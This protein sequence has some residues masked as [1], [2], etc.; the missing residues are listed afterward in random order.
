MKF[1]LRAWGILTTIPRRLLAQWGLVLAAI[2]GLVSSISLILSIPLYADAVYYRTLQ[3]TVNIDPDDEAKTRSPFSFLFHYYGGWHGN[4]K[5]DAIQPLDSYLSNSGAEVLGLPQKEFVRLIGTD[6]Y[7]LFPRGDFS[8]TSGAQIVRASFGTMTNLEDHITLLEGQVPRVIDAANGDPVEVLMSKATADETG[9]QVG[10][11][12]LSFI[13]QEWLFGEEPASQFP[14]RIVGVWEATNPTED[15]WISTPSYYQN[16]LFVPEGSF[17]QAID[18]YIPEAVFSAYWYMLMDGSEVYSDDVKPLLRRIYSLERYSGNLLPDVDLA[19]SP[20]KALADYQTAADLLTILLYA[21]S[22]PIIGL[23]LAFIG[24]VSRLSV[25]RQRNEIAVLRSRGATPMQVLGFTVLEGI[26]LGII[27]L[28]ISFPIAIQLTNWIGRTRSFL[29]FSSSGEL[30]VGIS[31]E[32]L[33]IGIVSVILVLIAMILPAISASRYTIV[34]YKRERGRTAAKPFWQ[35]AWLDVLLMIPAGYGIYLLQEQGRMVL[36]GE[37]QSGDLF[38]NPLL[39][40]VPALSIFAITLFSLRLIQPIM[41]GIAV[42]AAL[43]PSVGLTLATRQLSRSPGSYYTPLIILTL[44]ISLSSYTASLAYTL[45]QHLYDRTY[46]RIGADMRFLDVGDSGQLARLTGEAGDDGSGWVFIPVHEYIKIDGVQH[47]ARLGRY[48]AWGQVASGTSEGI[49]FGIDRLDFPRVVYWR[50]DFAGESLGA[51]MNL[52]ASDP[53]GILVPKD[54]LKQNSLRVGDSINLR[55]QAYDVTTQFTAK[56]VGSFEYFPMW[57][58]Q[59]GPLFVG[60]LDY[61]YQMAGG[62]FPYRVLLRTEPGVDPAE[63]GSGGLDSLTVNVRFISWDSPVIEIDETQALPERQGLF[64]FLFI[65]FATAALLT[66]L[67]FLLYVLFSFRQRFIELGVLRASGL[68]ITQMAVYVVWELTF[69]IL[70]GG[71]IGTGLGFWASKLF[72]PFLQ[73][74]S[75]ASSLIPPFQVLIAWP[76]IIQIYWMFAALFGLTIVVLILFLRRMRIFQAIKL[77][78]T[79]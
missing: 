64:G 32:V 10:E 44:T 17:A 48:T 24:L 36:M 3:E 67:A 77:G 31:G 1:F 41:A 4:L 26:V 21:F 46:Y 61:H 9:F 49:F 60:N 47:A 37:G 7:P 33:W 50:D 16:V 19:V 53:G 52:L 71:T 75:Q 18:Q 74:G 56:I 76:T 68:S 38:Q 55:I 69:L 6:A 79:L 23:I 35:R 11:I 43:T 2:F 63:L 12:Y 66:A 65:G 59:D 72:I 40:L 27:S 20:V 57:Y 15:Y 62:E 73:I 13:S 14:I 78:E 22:I 34:S 8:Y 51:L 45:D 28:L 54:Y 39:F 29:D 70:L 30:R 42:I 25:E 58:P 5:W